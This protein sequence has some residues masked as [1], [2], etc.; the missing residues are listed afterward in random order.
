M[1][2]GTNRFPEWHNVDRY[3]ECGP[4]E[5]VDL[6]RFPWPWPDGCADEVMFHH[7]LEHLGQAPDVFVGVMRELWRVSAPGARVAIHVPDPRHDDFL[8]DPTHVRPIT[9]DMLG[10]FSQTFNRECARSGAP[11]TPLG[12]IHG[13]DFEVDSHQRVF[14]A[15]WVQMLEQ[16]K[17]TTAEL[18]QSAMKFNN[19]VREHRFVLVALK[20]AV[21]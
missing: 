16:G 10:L 1:G 17:I 19:V 15:P 21:S 14:D 13:I 3:A 20:G 9:I 18:E 8:G 5:V 11:N 4:D 6:E 12:L 2:C 7:S